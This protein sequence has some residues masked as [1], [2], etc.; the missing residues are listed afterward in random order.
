MHIM[1]SQ[2]KVRFLG[3]AGDTI[4]PNAHAGGTVIFFSMQDCRPCARMAQ[5][6]VDRLVVLPPS[7]RPQ[8]W[9][10]GSER[11]AHLAELSEF[12]LDVLDVRP[13]EYDAF[14]RE[15]QAS[16]VPYVALL[17]TGG[18]VR[19]VQVGFSERLDLD[20]IQP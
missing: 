9:V 16:S 14:A 15:L 12:R 10:V 1:G 8:V 4:T 13:T 7:R 18:V 2:P 5:A 20:W 19:G 6:V 3:V 17:D 11:A